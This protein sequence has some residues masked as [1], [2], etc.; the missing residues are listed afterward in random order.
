MRWRG[1]T[2]LYGCVCGMG[3][4]QEDAREEESGE[5]L[6]F[7]RKRRRR[8]KICWLVRGFSFSMAR[9]I[10][11]KKKLRTP[12]SP[13][14]V[15]AVSQADLEEEERGRKKECRRITFGAKSRKWV[16]EEEE[17]KEERYPWHSPCPSLSLSPVHLCPPLP[18]GQEKHDDGFVTSTWGVHLTLALHCTALYTPP[19]V[20]SPHPITS[21]MCG[22][23]YGSLCLVGKSVGGRGGREIFSSFSFLF[24]TMI[25]LLLFFGGSLHK[26]LPSLFLPL[27]PSHRG[28]YPP[29]QNY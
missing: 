15:P 19:H 6:P 5:K 3:V 17:E 22:R 9:K 10:G 26:A 13:S 21:Q 29:S 28:N 1:Q 23:N 24:F 7:W 18:D 25:I 16:L 4:G 2:W 8:R 27:F 14:L 12:S 11:S 20:T